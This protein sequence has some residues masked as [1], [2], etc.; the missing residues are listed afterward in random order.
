MR[1]GVLQLIQRL[2]KSPT[3]PI[4]TAPVLYWEA[5]VEKRAPEFEPTAYAVGVSQ[6][7]EG[8]TYLVFQRDPAS[9]NP[10]MGITLGR[11]DTNDLR[12]EEPSISRFHAWFEQNEKTSEWFA[13]DADSEHGT[14]INGTRIEKGQKVLLVDNCPVR[15]GD[16]QTIFMLAATAD[17]FAR[18]AWSSAVP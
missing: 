11:A 5:G 12:I 2:A 13:R 14:F 9:T 16:V 10:M 18:K 6:K 1:L 7:A 4:F 17:A 15:V 3:G 8:P